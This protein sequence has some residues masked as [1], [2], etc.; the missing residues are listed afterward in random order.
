MPFLCLY[1]AAAVVNRSWRRLQ[2]G[3][4]VAVSPGAAWM[5]LLLIW[6]WEVFIVEMTRIQALLRVLFI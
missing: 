2:D 5:V 1:A 6:A 4:P 3:V